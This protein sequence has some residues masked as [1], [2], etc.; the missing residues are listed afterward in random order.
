MLTFGRSRQ[1]FFSFF[2]KKVITPSFSCWRRL[3]VRHGTVSLRCVFLLLQKLETSPPPLKDAIYFFLLPERKQNFSS[4]F[5]PIRRGIDHPKKLF[6]RPAPPL[7]PRIPCALPFDPRFVSEKCF[8]PWTH[9]SREYQPGRRTWRES[10][11]EA[12]FSCVSGHGW[13]RV[14]SKCG[15]CN[16]VQHLSEIK[17]FPRP[18]YE[19]IGDYRRALF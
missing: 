16:G 9:F 8:F 14:P 18:R 12:P 19:D 11:G 1:F 13:M 15:S 7:F 2:V 6:S 10:S 5:T 3:F 17:G 4:G